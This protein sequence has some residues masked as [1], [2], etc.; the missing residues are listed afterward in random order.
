MPPAKRFKWFAR[1]HL[2]LAALSF[3][4]LALATWIN[5]PRLPDPAIMFLEKPTT[6]LDSASSP[7]EWSMMGGDLALTRNL[8]TVSRPVLGMVV[9][10]QKLGGVPTHSAPT[11]SR[12]TLYAGG[13]FKVAALKAETGDQIWKRET[14]GPLHFSMPVAGDLV[15]AGLLDH[16]M[17]ALNRETGDIQW[18]FL[19]TNPI[20][21][22]PLVA[23][24]MVYFGTFDGLLHALDAATG[25][26]I[27]QRDNLGS[28]HASVALEGRSLVVTGQQGNLY[29]LD[30]R[31]G[32]EKLKFRAPGTANGPP[33]VANGLAYYPSGGTL[34]AVDA[35]TSKIPGEYNFG[36]VW[37]QFWVWGV[38]GVPK[39]PVQKGGIWRFSPKG[40]YPGSF[41]SSP[42]VTNDMLYLGD[43]KGDFY[44]IDALTGRE[45]WWVHSGAPILASP[46]VLGQRVHFGDKAGV[47]HALN[48]FTGESEW[49]LD[50]GAPIDIP[51]I[52]AHGRI[53][54]HTSDGKLHAIE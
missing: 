29:I 34:Y 3:V 20:I 41:S 11:A 42:A 6:N 36:L 4:V 40:A 49:E 48:R 12:E 18:E 25:N 38:P 54:V 16:R 22:S 46:L 50:L 44:G 5:Y 45:L 37:A 7:G 43:T 35:S 10:S 24:G 27:W 1:H 53:Y 51:P 8:P 30:S 2:I 52:Y 13:D 39:P 21:T 23:N 19:A 33:V 14:T 28:I 15:Y 26:L 31:T 9:W 17:L 47:L 32:R